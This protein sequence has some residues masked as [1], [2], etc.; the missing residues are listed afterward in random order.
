MHVFGSLERKIVGIFWAESARSCT[1]REVRRALAQQG[2]PVAY[3]TVMT[4]MNRLVD[5]RVLSRKLHGRGYAYAIQLD[6]KQAIK[7]A[8]E[9][10]MHALTGEFGETALVH[11]ADSLPELDPAVVK[12]LRKAFAK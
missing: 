7:Q 5:K 6:A 3:T 2:N 10:F 9:D 1:V 4:V 11:F 8:T 12:R